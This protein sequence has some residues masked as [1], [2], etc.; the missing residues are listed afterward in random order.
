MDEIQLSVMLH[1]PQTEDVL[2][3]LLAQFEAQERVRVRLWLLDWV[4]ARAELTRMAMYQ[5]GPDV[6]EVGTTWIPDL[7]AMN[8]L[9]PFTPKELAG[10]GGREAFVPVSWQTVSL[11][12]D[13]ACWALPWLAET[14][15]IH[16]R[17]DWLRQAGV[18]EASAFVDHA[19]LDATAARLA[20]HGVDVPVELP[21][22]S[23]RYGNLHS[24]A[25]WVW[26]RQ[27]SFVTPDGRKA[28]FDQPL[29]QQ[30][31]ADFFGL[32]RHLSP[33][34]RVLM[35]EKGA[36][37]LFRQGRSAIA[38]GTLHLT[39]P[40]GNVPVVAPEDWGVAPLPAPC[41]VGGSGLVAWRHTRHER[42]AVNL[43]RFLTSS[44]ALPQ[45]ARAMTALSPRLENLA[46]P[47]IQ[48]GKAVRINVSDAARIMAAALPSGR[49]YPAVGLW[50]MVEERLVASLLQI[51]SELLNDAQADLAAVIRQAVEPQVRRLNISLEQVR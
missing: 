23:D 20:A 4:T 22:E 50:G 29:V 5:Q 1:S 24:L 11:T 43:V 38:L 8:G 6:S 31:M 27:G 41:F 9:R 47:E 10:I 12:H 45:I 51:G 21:L 18:D 42:G 36:A 7:V 3:G 48:A 30:A 25:S 17:R 19:A 37:D 32:L 28:L 14:Y 16:Y 15:A 46:A 34:G 13:P 40:W 39:Q 2:R 33:A 35:S 49:T 26:G 44:A